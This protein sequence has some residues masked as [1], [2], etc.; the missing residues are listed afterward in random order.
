MRGSMRYFSLFSTYL[1]SC[2][3]GGFVDILNCKP[4]GSQW[5]MSISLHGNFYSPRKTGDIFRGNR[6][7]RARKFHVFEILLDIARL[8]DIC[9]MSTT[10]G[11]TLVPTY[12]VHTFAL[13][14]TLLIA[15][16]VWLF[17]QE[18]KSTLYALIWVCSFI[19]SRCEEIFSQICG[20]FF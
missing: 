18:K 9:H 20:P 6:E 16:H 2:S 19:N 8:P 5:Q 4:P 10:F 11:I 15:V 13:F 7:Q 14:W 12:T 3:I 17:F 1:K